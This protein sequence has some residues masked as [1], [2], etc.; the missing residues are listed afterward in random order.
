[1]LS[2]WSTLS[3]GAWNLVFVQM[4]LK[5]FNAKESTRHETL[6][7]EPQVNTD[8]A[9]SAL[10]EEPIGL[11]VQTLCQQY[12]GPQMAQAKQIWYISF[13]FMAHVLQEECV[14]SSVR[15]S[16]F[17]QKFMVLTKPWGRVSTE[18]CIFLSVTQMVTC[19]S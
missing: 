1:M 4:S 13:S 11:S 6:T 8:V 18:P 12:S 10:G 7:R 15:G 19:V 14:V 16:D 9:V 17:H 3:V 5:G 2:L